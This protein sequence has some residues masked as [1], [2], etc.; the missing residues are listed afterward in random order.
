MKR[1][2]CI[3]KVHIGDKEPL[4]D[5]RVTHGICEICYPKEIAKIDTERR[6][7]EK[8]TIIQR[9]TARIDLHS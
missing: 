5:K 4:D 6:Q 1:V 2:C 9:S 8:E 7:H 3:C